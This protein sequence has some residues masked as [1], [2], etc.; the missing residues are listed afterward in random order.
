MTSQTQQAL[1]NVA[2][3]LERVAAG[4]NYLDDVP[5]KELG[6]LR[7]ACQQL[8]AEINSEKAE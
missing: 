2:L 1:K 7:T 4:L 5:H 6:L 8:I 3:H